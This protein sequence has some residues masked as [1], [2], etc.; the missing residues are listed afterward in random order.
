MHA[1]T[2]I[3]LPQRG[4][5]WASHL[6]KK[7]DPFSAVLSISEST[8]LFLIALV[9]IWYYVFAYYLFLPLDSDF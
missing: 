5:A 8:L 4:R 7:K 9:I 6:K 1:S 3:V 2:E